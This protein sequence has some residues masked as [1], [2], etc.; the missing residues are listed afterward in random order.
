MDT[1]LFGPSLIGT[2]ADVLMDIVI[3]SIVLI[4]PLALWSIAQ[5]KRGGYTRHRNVQIT[6]AVVLAVVVG[7][8]EWDLRLKGGSN[9]WR[10]R[11]I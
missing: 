1:F 5:A 9:K 11:Q 4:V 2:R 10:R 7:F 3:G 8:F 6:L